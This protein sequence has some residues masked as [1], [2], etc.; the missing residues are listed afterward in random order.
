MSDPSQSVFEELGMV[1]QQPIGLV[2]TL[3]H[4][5]KI[6]AAGAWA[7]LLLVLGHSQLHAQESAQRA[8][9]AIDSVNAAYIRHMGTPDAVA[10]AEVYDADG[11]RLSSGGRVARGREAI[12]EAVSRF[13]VNVGPVIVSLQTLDLW[14][15]G[16]LAYETGTWSYTY[17]PPGENERTVGGQYVTVWRR[18]SDGGWRILA[19]MDVPGAG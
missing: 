1:R 8:R 3:L 17:T 15:V 13:V 10:F 14:V 9:A 11:A 16:D 2:V 19:D 6:I 12:T 18:Q 4:S 7:C 5:A